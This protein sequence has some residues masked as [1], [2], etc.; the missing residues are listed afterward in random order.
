MFASSDSGELFAEERASDEQYKLIVENSRLQQ[1]NEQLTRDIK[2]LQK[3]FD[4]LANSY[5]QIEKINKQNSEL[6]KQVSDL[7]IQNEE[8]NRR[9]NISLRSNTELTE[10]LNSIHNSYDSD[11]SMQISRLNSKIAIL[12]QQS[13]ST[14]NDL[15]E[16]KRELEIL[17]KK[18]ER[19][20]GILKNQVSKLLCL[21]QNYFKT[22][23]KSIDDLY[24][25]LLTSPDRSKSQ[26]S[27]NS[28]NE[29]PQIDIK[30]YESKIS[31]LKS[32]LKSEKQKKKQ[33]ELSFLKLR[34][35][36]ELNELK[37]SELQT[38]INDLNR[39]NEN[40]IKNLEAAHKQELLNLQNKSKY[41][42]AMIQTETEKPPQKA[43][44][45]EQIELNNSSVLFENQMKNSSNI[46]IIEK[47]KNQIRSLIVQLKKSEDK[48]DGLREK[49]KFLVTKINSLEKENKS[50]QQELFQTTMK[51]QHLEQENSSLNEQSE[52]DSTNHNSNDKIEIFKLQQS[53]E[54][55][56]KL[57][58]SQKVDIDKFTKERNHLLV[59]LQTQNEALN[60]FDQI[61]ET[62]KQV[63]NKQ[64]KPTEIEEKVE[65]I[66]QEEE[67]QWDFGT[68]PDSIISILK[69]LTENEGF[70]M[71][72]KIHHVFNVI[73]KWYNNMEINH[74][75][76]IIEY[77]EK[78][79]EV[80]EQYNNFKDN[81]AGALGQADI[82]PQDI[83]NQI[84]EINNQN[85]LL[86]QKVNELERI[87]NEQTISLNESQE[88][89][90]KQNQSNLMKMQT[91]LKELNTKCKQRKIQLKEFK[92]TFIECQKRSDEEI[93][94]LR[95]TNQRTRKELEEVHNSYNELHEKYKQL[96]DEIEQIHQ[97]QSDEINRSNEDFESMMIQNTSNFDDYQNMMN[98]ELANKK[99]EI[100]E[101]NIRIEDL[102]R[103]I[104]QQEQYLKHYEEDN[105]K[106][107]GQYDKLKKETDDRITFLEEQ[108]EE[109]SKEIEDHFN[110][111]YDSL[112]TK[113]KELTEQVKNLMDP[114]EKEKRDCETIKN[115][116]EDKI[117]QLTYQ[118]QQD[119]AKFESIQDNLE[120]QNK[121]LSIQNNA[122][123]MSIETNCSIKCDEIKKEYEMKKKELLGFI[124]QQFRP[125]YD[126]KLN[127]DE[128][129]IKL[130]VKQINADITTLKKKDEGMRKL[131]MAK[132]NQ[133]TEDALTE[134]ILS[135]HPQ[136]AEQKPKSKNST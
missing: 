12:K 40:K 99:N 18:N 114:I 37:V 65:I 76:E 13:Q 8:L 127:L 122:K 102:K 11:Y 84:N 4:E 97:H 128:D 32:Q 101:L 131:L 79:D 16:K 56:E 116:Y 69:T 120:R 132:D 85:A 67:I 111:T 25:N 136:L 50:I 10:K 15:N 87:Q 38:Q 36:N 80:S 35:Q 88:N 124:A 5:P 130:I 108:K 109:F 43:K 118:L 63:E 1:T 44:E 83:I 73:S 23:I 105:K 46:D 77:K 9:L 14:I 22:E 112:I 123:L 135:M 110:K 100:S 115:E 78:I 82:Q 71:N 39:N 31:H 6:T 72:S 89:Q 17:L 119:R 66:Q 62:M 58:S 92:S 60:S 33:I 55:L 94:T 42:T 133:S 24:S 129:A 81:L 34:K 107:R 75:N 117:S 49:N 121:L 61:I 134:L 98:A 93:K 57:A 2:I 30:N 90:L 104:E 7:N 74:E 126:P 21:S 113:N 41:K 45:P 96:S 26:E 52:A 86:Q 19:E 29:E 48:Q 27:E 125:F 103:K 3:Q 20:Y 28:T 95:T 64:V 53:I 91:A 59:L 47:M 70:S 68:L 54:L 106:L 51:I